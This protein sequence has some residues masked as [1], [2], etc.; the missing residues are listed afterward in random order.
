QLDVDPGDDIAERAVTERPTSE[1]SGLQVAVG[2]FVERRD[3]FV[4]QPAE[5]FTNAVSAARPGHRFPRQ[6]ARAEGMVEHHRPP[7][8]DVPRDPRDAGR[9][10]IVALVLGPIGAPCSVGSAL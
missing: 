4:A 8:S 7:E 9:A 3:P 10:E 6:I 1:L 2:E 5:L